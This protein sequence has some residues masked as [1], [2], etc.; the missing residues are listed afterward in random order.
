MKLPPNKLKKNQT[1]AKENGK[2]VV[3]IFVK[4]CQLR[5]KSKLKAYLYKDASFE[6]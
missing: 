1:Q 4:K 3:W 6:L 5:C 2:L